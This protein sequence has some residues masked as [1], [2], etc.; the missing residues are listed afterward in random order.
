MGKNIFNMEIIFAQHIT[1][2]VKRPKA[3]GNIRHWQ[4][5]KNI[6]K[7]NYVNLVLFEG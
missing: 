1:L 7:A 2:K 6:M 5:K 4:K 3:G